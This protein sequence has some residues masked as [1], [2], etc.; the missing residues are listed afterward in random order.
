[1]SRWLGNT[2]SSLSA[3]SALERGTLHQANINHI[4]EAVCRFEDP[5][6]DSTESVIAKIR[7]TKNKLRPSARML[8]GRE[9]GSS[10][11]GTAPDV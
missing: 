1:M 11:A 10:Y 8:A 4:I 9:T 6:E 2:K 3:S 5:V 7:T